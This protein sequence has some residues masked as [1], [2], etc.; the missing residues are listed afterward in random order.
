M[1]SKF[2]VYV[3]LQGGG[4]VQNVGTDN[5][6]ILVKVSGMQI[7]VVK[8]NYCV[9]PYGFLASRDIAQGGSLNNGLKDQRYALRWIKK[10]IDRFGGDP[11]HVVLDGSGAGA[12]SVTLQLA[13]YGGKD[14]GLFHATAAESQ[15]FAALRTLE[16]SEYQ[17]DELVERTYCS[18]S[19]TTSDDTLACLRAL[20]SNELQRVNIGA[21]FPNTT[22]SPLF[23][24][25]PTLNHDFIPD[26]TLD[27]F[28]SGRFLKLPAIYGDVT[29]EGTSFV[30]R[31]INS[32]DESNDWLQAQF[33]LLNSTQK[34]W[35]QKTY[36]PGEKDFA[37]TGSR[38]QPT[39]KAYGEL[40]YICPVLF[41]NNAYVSHG[42][43]NTWN[44]R[45]A[46]LDPDESRNGIGTPHGAELNAIWDGSPG[47]PPSYRT[48]NADMI[49]ILH[50]Y[51]ISFIRTFDPNTLRLEGTPVWEAWSSAGF[52]KGEDG[53]RRIVFQNGG[54]KGI[55]METV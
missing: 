10:H 51:W 26:Y 53:R 23:A 8:L 37:A 16:E 31:D 1:E 41:L 34:K 42:L 17:Y 21:P 3:Y 19:D 52:D 20:S 32:M 38:W 36:T 14:E 7:V 29:N 28:S 9:G 15:S 33:P 44:Y 24:Y 4:F 18:A 6:A 30:T 47:S 45:Y 50:H 22:R 55:K 35:I 48:T 49:P 13:A 43:R 27:P 40:R 25:N 46:V 2:S 5:G 11:M 39:A 54:A 12:A